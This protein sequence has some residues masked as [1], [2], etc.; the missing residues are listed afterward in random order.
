MAISQT[1]EGISPM[2]PTCNNRQFDSNPQTVN[3]VQSLKT[4]LFPALI[5]RNGRSENYLPLSLS[6]KR[7]KIRLIKYQLNISSQKILN[8]FSK[9][10]RKQIRSINDLN[11][12][13]IAKTTM[14][15]AQIYDDLFQFHINLKIKSI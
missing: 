3:I 9:N 5:P 4:R 10:A 14:Q 15:I 13:S 11:I 1:A 2:D 12:P 7:I 8:L 6:F